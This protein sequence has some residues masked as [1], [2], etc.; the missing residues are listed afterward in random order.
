[1]HVVAIV[2]L[3]N[4]QII[5]FDLWSRGFR[6]PSRND[7]YMPCR[8]SIF[9][10]FLCHNF[11]PSKFMWYCS[12]RKETTCLLGIFNNYGQSQFGKVFSN[13]FLLQ[14][15]GP[16][17]GRPPFIHLDE[18]MARQLQYIIALVGGDLQKSV[19]TPP[20]HTKLLL[21][22]VKERMIVNAIQMGNNALGTKPCLA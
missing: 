18:F 14:S 19:H 21:S 10:R 12:T 7:Y 2:L 5:L 4:D 13:V 9:W 15:R 8:L 6:S 17:D 3:I 1:M 22:K 16:S 20:P 11:I